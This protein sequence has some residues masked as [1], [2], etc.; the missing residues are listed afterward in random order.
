MV[1]L[2]SGQT[3]QY[4][5]DDMATL[6][7]SNLHLSQKTDNITLAE[8]R[9]ISGNGHD[10][11]LSMGRTALL[12]AQ[13]NWRG[14][15]C[16]QIEATSPGKVKPGSDTPIAVTVLHK[17]DGSRVPSKLEAAL[18]GETSLVPTSLAKTPGTLTYTAP[19]QNGKSATIKLTATSRRGIATLDLSAN[20]G[21]QSFTLNADSNGAHFS[22][23]ICSLD[24]PFEITLAASGET[25]TE[26]ATPNSSVDGT[27]AGTYSVEGCTF[28]GSGPYNIIMNTNGSATMQWTNN[29]TAD[30]PGLGSK[31]GVVSH[32]LPLQPAPDN[33]C[34]K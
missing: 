30:C 4:N 9:E 11:A 22:A 23:T 32:E 27:L 16:V 26:S 21:G 15:G 19:G 20:T 34:S 17:F 2:E 1:Y 12:V 31:S 14:G 6:Q 7:Y 13:D 3:I 5:A 18:S 25:W 8:G 29:W 33:A 28:T 24:Q 10:A